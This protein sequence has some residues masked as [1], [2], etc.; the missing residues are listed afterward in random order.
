MFLQK[1]SQPI[2]HCVG[3]AGG[4]ICIN[5]KAKKGF[6]CLLLFRAHYAIINKICRIKSNLR[7]FTFQRR[8]YGFKTGEFFKGQIKPK[9]DWRAIDSPKKRT[10]EFVFFAMT[11]RK[12]LKLEISISSFKY[13]RTVKQKKQIGSF[14]FWENLRR[15]NLLTVLSD[16][17]QI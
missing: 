12:Y 15:A 14:G 8:C 5:E 11:V 10:N 13:F 3:A 1:L 9:A 17:Q 4:K 7:Y 6:M 16:L 2:T